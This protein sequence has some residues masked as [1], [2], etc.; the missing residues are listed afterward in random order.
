MSTLLPRRRDSQK[1]E[2]MQTNYCRRQIL[3]VNRSIKI[4]SPPEKPLVLSQLC[5]LPA[6]SE[7][8]AHPA[9]AFS[10]DAFVTCVLVD[11]RAAAG[12]LPRRI[13]E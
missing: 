3:R 5:L 1:N 2:S 7:A 6:I 12:N 13:E 4:I 11:P 10:V 9:K 8:L